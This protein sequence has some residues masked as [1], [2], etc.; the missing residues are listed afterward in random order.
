M[1]VH[2][3]EADA[4]R[5]AASRTNRR[6]ALRGHPKDYPHGFVA[7]RFELDQ[8]TTDM[9]TGDLETI[10]NS[11]RQCGLVSTWHQAQPGAI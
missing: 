6:S 4:R 8:P 2:W 10:R 9:V 11:M 3:G 7:R 5:F 1:S